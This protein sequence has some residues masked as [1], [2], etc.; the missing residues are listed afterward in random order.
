[1]P[2]FLDIC[3]SRGCSG[4]HCTED[5]VMKNQQA[6]T[7]L[8][9]ILD[10]MDSDNPGREWVKDYIEG[11]E[12]VRALALTDASEAYYR[13]NQ[14]N[15]RQAVRPSDRPVLYG[16]MLSAWQDY[17][18]FFPS[19]DEARD[20]YGA[21][22]V[23]EE[24]GDMESAFEAAVAAYHAA[25]QDLHAQEPGTLE[26]DAADA[27]FQSAWAEVQTFFPGADAAL[28]YLKPRDEEAVEEASWN[29]RIATAAYRI[30][31]TEYRDGIID[32]VELYAL[33]QRLTDAWEVVVEFFP[34]EEAAI[35]YIGR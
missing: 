2:F 20:D 32:A 22:P 25:R 6:I 3:P 27:A 19:E 9:A 23:V 1:M 5:K 26:E 7:A 12:A 35:A 10:T 24:P 21:G 29:H 30:G 28:S 33:L 11:L 17:C 31:E 14:A 15:L 13:A 34:N 4:N 8:R 18:S 16:N